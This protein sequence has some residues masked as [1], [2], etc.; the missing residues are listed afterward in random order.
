L[1]NANQFSSES[2]TTRSHV[3]T[4]LLLE[5]G[6]LNWSHVRARR[7]VWRAC[8]IVT[9]NMTAT[10]RQTDGRTDR[11]QYRSRLEDTRTL[12]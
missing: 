5:L 2:N 7:R 6:G 10:D 12:K 8:Y 9:D 1:R 3:I 4:D 11:R